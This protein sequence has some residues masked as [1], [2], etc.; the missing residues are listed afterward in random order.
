M[1]EFN[2]KTKSF[3]FVRLVQKVMSSSLEVMFVLLSDLFKRM[4]ACVILGDPVQERV[5]AL[6]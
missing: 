5:D 6:L 1:E 4:C 2:Y 3:V